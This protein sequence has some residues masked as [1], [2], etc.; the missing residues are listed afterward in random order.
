MALCTGGPDSG[1]AK[2][3]VCEATPR[4]GREEAVAEGGCFLSAWRCGS[5]GESLEVKTL[6]PSTMTSSVS[7]LV[8]MRLWPLF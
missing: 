4:S 6:G 2:T 8:T 7:A 3:G 5:V 1:V